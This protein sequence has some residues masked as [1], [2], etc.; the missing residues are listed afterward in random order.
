MLGGAAPEGDIRI[1]ENMAALELAVR[2]GSPA[3]ILLDKL[4]TGESKHLGDKVKYMFSGLKHGMKRYTK[5]KRCNDLFGHECLRNRE[6]HA[7]DL[8]LD[9]CQIKG[10]FVCLVC[11]AT[12]FDLRHLMGHLL[13]HSSV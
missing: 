11:F 4:I 3:A 9:N 10:N 12:C 1:S 5:C 6:V 13:M 7:H 8:N 2:N